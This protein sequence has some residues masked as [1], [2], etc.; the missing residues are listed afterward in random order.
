MEKQRFRIWYIPVIAVVLAAL[1][2]GL[3]WGTIVVPAPIMD[4]TKDPALYVCDQLD[5]YPLTEEQREKVNANI[6]EKYGADC[7]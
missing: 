2:T 6:K 3:Q 7:P 4:P 1:A 5:T